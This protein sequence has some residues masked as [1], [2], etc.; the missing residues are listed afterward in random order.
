MKKEGELNKFKQIRLVDIQI[1]VNFCF[2]NN[3]HKKKLKFY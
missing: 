1:R 2:E 3:S